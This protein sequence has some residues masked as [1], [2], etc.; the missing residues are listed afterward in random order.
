MNSKC[1]VQN[2]GHLRNLGNLFCGLLFTLLDSSAVAARA[3]RAQEDNSGYLV[4]F[5]F[6]FSTAPRCMRSSAPR[7]LQAMTPGVA[8]I[9]A[10]LELLRL[11]LASSCKVRIWQKK[12]GQIFPMKCWDNTSW[13][14]NEIL[15]DPYFDSSLF[16]LLNVTQ[17]SWAKCHESQNV[18]V[19]Q[20]NSLH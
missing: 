11:G 3:P 5:Q 10:P 13:K 18:L 16:K 14:S 17:T 9:G 8:L 1:Q 19:F 12:L 4:A 6:N 2:N 7:R 15:A 20:T